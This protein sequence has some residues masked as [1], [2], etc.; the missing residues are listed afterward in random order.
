MSN[1]KT[2]LS[3]K[4][5]ELWSIDPDAMVLEAIKIMADKN[6]GALTVVK[7]EKLVGIISERDYTH[8]V[9]LNNRASNETHVKDIMSRQVFYTHPEQNIDECM[10]LMSEHR[11]RHLPV[12]ENEKLLGM[13]SIG[14]VVKEIIND[15]KYTIKQLENYI[16]WEENY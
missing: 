11:I 10:I 3:K 12:L 6:V 4:T 16:S 15:Q 2:I 7:D 13:I 9:I 5:S 14:D 8:K 1:V